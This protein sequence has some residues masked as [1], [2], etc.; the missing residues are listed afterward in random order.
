MSIRWLDKRRFHKFLFYIHSMDRCLFSFFS[1]TLF[2]FNL[3]R[4]EKGRGEIS[5]E[6]E[7]G[8]EG[9]RE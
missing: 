2:C 9:G 5:K 4:R 3:K 8:G 1:L 7:K 6:R